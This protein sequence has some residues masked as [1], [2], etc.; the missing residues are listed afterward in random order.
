MDTDLEFILWLL[1]STAST[2]EIERQI[3]RRASRL[4]ERHDA[5]RNLA[6]RPAER[7]IANMEVADLSVVSE[8]VGVREGVK[9]TPC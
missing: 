4:S 7:A 8:N 6:V 1:D 2:V 5:D 3:R 9:A